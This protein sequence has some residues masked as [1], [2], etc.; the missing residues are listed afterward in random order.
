MR[1]SGYPED[2]WVGEFLGEVR[3]P[4]PGTFKTAIRFHCGVL[5]QGPRLA[6][7]DQKDTLKSRYF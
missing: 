2:V 3:L 7:N 5:D 4:E 1:Y 6:C